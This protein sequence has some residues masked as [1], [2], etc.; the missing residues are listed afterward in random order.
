MTRLCIIG[1]ITND[2]VRQGQQYRELA[3]GVP[4]YAGIAAERLGLSISVLTKMVKADE[5]KLCSPLLRSGIPIRI[6]ESITTTEF[7]NYYDAKSWDIRKQVVRHVA[8]PFEVADIQGM[9]ADLY[10]A[11]PLTAQDMPLAFIEELAK[12]GDVILDAQG[13][14]RRIQKHQVYLEDWKD[15]GDYLSLVSVVKVDQ[16]EAHILTQ[17]TDL[18]SAAKVLASYGPRQVIITAAGEG[19]LVWENGIA[20]MIS[21]YRPRKFVDPTGC[22][23]TYLAAFLF[24]R[25]SG[26]D[27]KTSGYFAAAAAAL[28]IEKFGPFDGNARDVEK[29]QQ[30]TSMN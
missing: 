20:Y 29:Y 14:V 10:Y 25:L 5:A 8:E 18:I 22:G 17:E 15:K 1:H 30:Q 9:A 11:G 27:A 24:M 23:D 4:I 2:V 3:G 28:K 21:A 13:F 26:A 16:Y 6:I 7:E 12:M 19:S